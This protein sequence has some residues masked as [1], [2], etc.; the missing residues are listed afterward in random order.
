MMRKFSAMLWLG[1]TA[2]VASSLGCTMCNTEHMCDYGGAGG[3]WQR[4]NPTCGR[5]GSILSDAGATQSATTVGYT[6][7][8][9]DSWGL[10][11]GQPTSVEGQVIQ[12]ELM[13]ED[14]MPEASSIMISP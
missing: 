1:L 11:D 3:K 4:G 5:V 2:L 10:V 7:N 9:G 12:E 13:P 8:Y 14:I 6:E